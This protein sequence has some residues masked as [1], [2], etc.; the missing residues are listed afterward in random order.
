MRA[1]EVA[2]LVLDIGME[3]KGGGWGDALFLLPFDLRCLPSFTL[4]K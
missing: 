3:V 2:M 1:E 4:K